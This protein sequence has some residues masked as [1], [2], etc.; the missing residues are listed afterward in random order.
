MAKETFYLSDENDWIGEFFFDN[1]EHRFFG[2]L[3]FSPTRGIRVEFTSPTTDDEGV[4]TRRSDI[5][6]GVLSNGRLCTIFGNF[7]LSHSGFR[8]AEISTR[9]GVW[10]ARFVIIGAHL[11]M[12]SHFD[13]LCFDF[14]NTQEFFFPQGFVDYVHYKEGEIFSA[15]FQ[16]GKISVENSA[17]FKML[18][19]DLSSI[20]LSDNPK[21][22]QELQDKWDEI[23][24]KYE[25]ETL[26]FKSSL[27]Y[28]Y[29][30]KKK[31]RDSVESLITSMFD[32]ANL[33]ALLM[34]VPTF[35]KEVTLIDRIEDDK[36][37]SFPVLISYGL[38]ERT[39]SLATRERHHFHLPLTS[40]NVDLEKAIVEWIRLSSGYS[41]VVSSIQNETGFISE[42]ESHSDI[43][44]FSTQLEEINRKIGG[45]RKEK[46]ENPITSIGSSQMKALLAHKLA[47]RDSE[48]I[49]SKV[50]DLRN[51]IAHV[52]KPKSLLESI[53]TRDQAIIAVC[54]KLIVQSHILSEIGINKSLIHKYQESYL[55]S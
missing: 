5:L 9:F 54:L 28:Y 13:E 32:L 37:K 26:M 21:V 45:S 14:E 19:N 51:E 30:L 1:Y 12:D 48:S 36:A 16:E 17:S 31:R 27:K 33:M 23:R 53:S 29:R 18:P 20:L 47:V 24:S 50:G 25:N 7:D 11:E 49:G 10:G 3:M 41:S 52:G 43:V 39:L 4:K 6:Y 2:K 8:G 35:A 34:N 55:P 38:S 40:K 42:H 15:D 46:Y 44:L 22:M